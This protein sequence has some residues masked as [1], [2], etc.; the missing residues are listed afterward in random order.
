MTARPEYDRLYV[1]FVYYFNVERDYFECHE[2]MEEL[3]LEEGRAPLYQ[4]LLQVAVGLYHHRNGNVSGAI[5]LFTAALEKLAGRQAEVMGIDLAL[6]VADS[7][8]YLQQLERMTEQPFTFYDLNIR[9]V[10]PSLDEAVGELIANPPL[11]DVEE[12]DH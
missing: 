12:E 4:G 7:Q 2:V 1:K 11:P 8:R 5:K 10:D 3:W 6:L 9:V